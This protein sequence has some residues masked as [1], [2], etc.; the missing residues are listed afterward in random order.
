MNLL[1]VFGGPVERNLD[2]VL[3][4]ERN[5]EARAEYAEFVFVEFLLLV[6]DVLA[7]ARFS[8]AVPLDGARQNHGRAAAMLDGRFVR[9]VNLARIVAAEAQTL[10]SLVGQRLDQLQQPRITAK[11]MLAH[12]S[13]GFDD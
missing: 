8:Q 2:A 5:A 3:I 4:V 7:F 13:P 6:G 12:I 1:T 10:E 9:S 11:E